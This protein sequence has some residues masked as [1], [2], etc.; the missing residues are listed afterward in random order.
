MPR[1]F[2]LP[3]VEHLVAE[4]QLAS[5]AVLETAATIAVLALGAEYPEL[6]SDDVDLREPPELRAAIDLIERAHA[7]DLTITRYRRALAERH[8]REREE[9]ELLPF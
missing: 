6:A 5:L 3:R 7:L 9:D 2:L 8:E 4:P 1:A